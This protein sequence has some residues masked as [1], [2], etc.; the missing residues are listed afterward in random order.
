[1]GSK[2][3]KTKDL[4]AIGY[5]T[6]KLKSL[7]VIVLN[8]EFKFNTKEEI[9]NILIDIKNNPIN[10]FENKNLKKLALEF[11]DKIEEKKTN[12]FEL[13]T[14]RN[15]F[16]V[17]G[18]QFVNENTIQQM[19]LAMQLPIS[20]YGALMPDAHLGYGL[21]IGG[22]LATKNSVIP[23][24]IGM[25][26]ACRMSLTIYQLPDNFLKRYAYLIKANLKEYTHFGMSQMKAPYNN[27]SI[28]EDNRFQ[29]TALLKKMHGKARMQLGSS[30]SGNH[31]VEF[32]EIDLYDDNN[33]KLP[34]GKYIGILAHSGSRG[35]GA[36]IAN[37]Y[38]QI[39]MNTCKLPKSVQHLAWLDLNTQEGMEYWLSMELAGDYAKACHE[40]IHKNL[41][42]SLGIKPIA[43]IENHHNFAW[44]ENIKGEDLVV[45]RKG[46]TPAYRNELGVIPANMIDSAHIVLGLGNEDVLNS[47]SHGAGRRL[48]RKAAKESITGSELRKSLKQNGVELIGGNTD[49]A[50]KSYKNLEQ[51]MK[52]QSKSVKT[53]GKF[54]PK[55]VRMD[56]A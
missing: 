24:A 43:K 31:F 49:E 36:E 55:I 2:K 16:K 5:N 32:G 3:I 12:I 54:H 51:V 38:K 26:I 7:V 34:S 29:E 40:T 35:L 42:K 37:Y 28:L 20:K 10:Y 25:D 8:K 13:K 46:A 52:A 39:A 45:H 48:S 21:P 4:E 30:G 17:I 15:N 56:K 9:L 1:M 23:Y 44:K 19:Q 22:V 18:N 33:L 53:I 11:S 50:P 41:A 47:A 6:H 27:H 14:E